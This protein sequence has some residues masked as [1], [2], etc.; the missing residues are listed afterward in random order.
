MARISLKRFQGARLDGGAQRWGWVASNL[1][2]GKGSQAAFSK[3]GLHDA[4]K[5]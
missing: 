4:I 1:E 2:V 5:P 3:Q